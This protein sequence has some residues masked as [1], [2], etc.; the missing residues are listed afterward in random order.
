[1]IAHSLRH[2]SAMPQSHIS[3]V[4]SRCF[5]RVGFV[6]VEGVT[7]VF[8]ALQLIMSVGIHACE[9]LN[10]VK[11][12]FWAVYIHSSE[13]NR[14]LHS[15]RSSTQQSRL[16]FMLINPQWKLILYIYLKAAE[17]IYL[18]V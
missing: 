7:H 15:A 16:L 2:M 12:F 4:W 3:H 13:N 11:L 9:R 14:T 6:P 17:R 1:M 8:Q 5:V 18:S 10:V